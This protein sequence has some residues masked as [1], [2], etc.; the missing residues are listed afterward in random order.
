MSLEMFKNK[1]KIICLILSIIF[2]GNLFVV[3]PFVLAMDDNDEE[4]APVRV[5]AVNPFINVPDSKGWTLLM[6][7][8][9]EHDSQLVE[10]LLKQGADLNILPAELNDAYAN[11]FEYVCDF[12]IK[13][14][15]GDLV[16]G[17][18]EKE[19]WLISKEVCQ[20]YYDIVDIILRH[21][22]NKNIRLHVNTST[23]T[24]HE[25]SVDTVWDCY[26]KWYY[27]ELG[28]QYPYIFI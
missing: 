24:N 22:I 4:L 14:C 20:D 18:Y 17:D 15:S 11:A 19:T 9:R 23:L 25:D 2:A 1:K 6:R 27:W 12:V 10:K 16:D 5:T 26:G 21:C 3:N 7:A 28:E 8:I 13:T